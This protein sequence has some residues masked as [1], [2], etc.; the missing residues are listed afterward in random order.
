MV[1]I[2]APESTGCTNLATQHDE[3]ILN[4]QGE[5]HPLVQEEL[6]PLA[7]I[8]S[9]GANGLSDRVMSIMLMSWRISMESAYP[10]VWRRWS[11][12]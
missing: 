11:S 7:C 4:P 6:L 8:E 1:P 5:L 10:S 2:T 12:W 3:E 9:Y